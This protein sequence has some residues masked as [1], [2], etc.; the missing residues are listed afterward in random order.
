MQSVCVVGATLVWGLSSSALALRHA[1][2]L[3]LFT[4]GKDTID[5]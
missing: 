4:H 5:T 1:S 3:L 2:G